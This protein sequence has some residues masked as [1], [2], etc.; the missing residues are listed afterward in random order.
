MRAVAALA[1]A[2]TTQLWL[3]AA[4]AAATALWLVIAQNAPQYRHG[5]T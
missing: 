5:D 1:T 2:R 3:F 4:L